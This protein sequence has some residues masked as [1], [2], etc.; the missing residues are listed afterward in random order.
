VK[1]NINSDEVHPGLSNKG[2]SSGWCAGECW[3]IVTLW[4]DLPICLFFPFLEEYQEIESGFKIIQVSVP[5]LV[6]EIRPNFGLVF[7]NCHLTSD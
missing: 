4:L 2:A 6:L 5:V 7:N 1:P 3:S